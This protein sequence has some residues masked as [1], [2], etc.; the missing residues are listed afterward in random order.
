MGRR[1]KITWDVI[2]QDY[3]SHNPKRAKEVLRFQPYDFATILLIFQSG[4]RMTY[5]YDTKNLKVI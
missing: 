4:E 5:N 1:K 2:F 3:K